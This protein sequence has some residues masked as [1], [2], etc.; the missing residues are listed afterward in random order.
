MDRYVIIYDLRNQRDYKPLWAEL[1][2]LGGRRSLES[3]WCLEIGG[4]NAP[5]LRDHFAKFIDRDDGLLIVKV[6]HWAA[7]RLRASPSDSIAA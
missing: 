3:T 2:A 4:T 7:L 6:E 1:L 5:T